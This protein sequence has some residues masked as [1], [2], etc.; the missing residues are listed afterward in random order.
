MTK[1]RSV[2]PSGRSRDAQKSGRPFSRVVAIVVAL[3]EYRKPS[4]GAALPKVDYARKDAEAF[5]EAVKAMFPNMPRSNLDVKVIT[6]SSATLVGLRDDV[7]HTIRGLDADDLFIFYYAG[8]GFHGAG[9][10]RLSVYDTNRDNIDGTSFILRDDLLDPL[11]ESQCTRSLIFVDACAA[12]FR[13]LI[14]SRDAITDLSADEVEKLLDDAWYCGVFLSCSPGEKSYPSDIHEHGIWTYYLLEALSG[15]ADRALTRERWLTDTGLR[16]YLKLEV[17]QYLT[18]RTKVSGHQTP[19]AIISSSSSFDI[20]RFEPPVSSS[21]EAML[22]GIKLLNDSEFLEGT[23][24]G[25]VSSLEGFNKRSHTV[26]DRESASAA[27]WYKRLLSDQI[28]QDVQDVYIR[29]KRDLGLRRRDIQKAVELD[30]GELDTPYFRYSIEP[31][32]SPEEPGE[33]YIRRQL[34]LRPGWQERREAIDGMFGSHFDRVV[35]ELKSVGYSF[36]DLVEE[37]ETVESAHGGKVQDDD[38]TQRV[39]YEVDG[40]TFTF[41]LRQRRLEV[42]FNRFGGLDLVDEMQRYP[43]GIDQD[44]PMLSSSRPISTRRIRADD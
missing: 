8:H 27:N 16:D 6:D 22:A 40:A 33:Y 30:G 38:K 2:A 11:S 34:A 31:G 7:K 44:S 18:K 41:D 4:N 5:G 25:S 23:D 21:P 32:Q 24:T 29:A 20:C 35:I 17:S 13:D 39:T 9:G 15:R 1:S 10:N 42:S 19:Q 3:E 14:S 12:K 36:D 26:P 43:L 37:L 28:E